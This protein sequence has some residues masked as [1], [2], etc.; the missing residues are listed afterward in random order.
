MEDQ[1]KKCAN[2]DLRS[3]YKSKTVRGTLN[4]LNA[5]HK[6]KILYITNL[7]NLVNAKGNTCII[8]K[9]CLY[10]YSGNNLL[11]QISTSYE[12]AF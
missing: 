12:P 6:L 9:T 2:F 11:Q 5:Y 8:K 10:N 1:K 4:L 3:Q 7:Y